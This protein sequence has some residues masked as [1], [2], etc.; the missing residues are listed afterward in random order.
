MRISGC[1]K[2]VG[3]ET[4]KAVTRVVAYEDYQ[5][6]LVSGMTHNL[7]CPIQIRDNRLRVNDKLKHTVQNPSEYHHAITVPGE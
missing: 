7:I 2:D 3:D 4:C 1:K 5:A 6:L